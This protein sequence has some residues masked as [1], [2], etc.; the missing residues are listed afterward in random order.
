MGGVPE[1]ML[2]ATPGIPIIT[3]E[4]ARWKAGKE[5]VV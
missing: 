2:C 3:K 4:W 5:L 1:K